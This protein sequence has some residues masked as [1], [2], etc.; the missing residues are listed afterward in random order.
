VAEKYISDRDTLERLVRLETKVDEKFESITC[1]IKLARD[2]AEKAET[3]ARN[4]TDKHFENI[5]NFQK[6][7][8]KL[9]GTFATKEGL[10]SRIFSLNERIDA[11]SKL[12]YIGIGG[13]LVLE[14]V[15]KFI[16]H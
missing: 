5:N 14:L 8:D 2:V 13:V 11:L 1:N 6:R 9:E 7:I 4:Q 15:F 16:I 3:L 10:D 12:V